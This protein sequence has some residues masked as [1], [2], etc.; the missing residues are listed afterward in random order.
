M[1]IDQELVVFDEDLR[2]LSR[3]I[4]QLASTEDGT[5]DQADYFLAE[6]VTFRLF[7]D[8]E[9][10][11]RAVFLE[12]CVIAVSPQGVAIKSKLK[13]SDWDT[14]EEILKSGNKFLEWGN[15]QN[16][17][18]AANL[19]FDNGYPIADLVGPIG[20]TLSDLHRFRNFIAHSSKEAENG[21][22]KTLPQYVKAGHNWPVSVG[23]LAVYRRTAR[24]DITLRIVF[25]KV[26]A[27]STIYR[28]L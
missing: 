27:L 20:N 16:V 1:S 3:Y 7:R 23:E 28:E 25:D 18:K 17:R 11:I 15:V 22:K 8:Y 2:L 5:I 12:S 6:A 21:F 24:A 26:S 4:D 10:L 9:R 13:C 19:I 14:A